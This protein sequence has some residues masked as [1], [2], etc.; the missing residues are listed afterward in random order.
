M[1]L[2]EPEE[3]PVS[4]EEC[5]PSYSVDPQRVQAV[6]QIIGSN[7]IYAAENEEQMHRLL[8]EVMDLLCPEEEC[9]WDEFEDD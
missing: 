3:Q 4:F 7:G 9:E 5:E 2:K 8:L 6:L 1:C